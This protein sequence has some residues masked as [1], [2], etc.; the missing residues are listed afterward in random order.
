MNDRDRTTTTNGSLFCQYAVFGL[1]TIQ[2]VPLLYTLSL[3]SS[4]TSTSMSDV[5]IETDILSPIGIQ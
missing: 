1:L 3:L 4:S 5:V 2:S